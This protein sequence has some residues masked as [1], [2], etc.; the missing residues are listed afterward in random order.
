MEE[1]QGRESDEETQSCAARSHAAPSPPGP[2]APSEDQGLPECANSAHDLS[3]VIQGAKE[4]TAAKM[5]KRADRQM[6][7]SARKA[8]LQA[9]RNGK[10]YAPGIR[11]KLKVCEGLFVEGLRDRHP[12]TSF[13]DW[14]PKE[15][16]QCK[17]LLDKY[18]FEVVQAAL[19]YVVKH[20]DAIQSR[21]NVGPFPSL[22]WVVAMH[23]SLVPEAQRFAGIQQTLTE[24]SAWRKDHPHDFLPPELKARYNKIKPELEALGIDK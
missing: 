4:K 11:K 21:F 20:W 10:T 19:E 1:N 15:R 18:P 7:S 12:E 8:Q 22:G 14:G 24:I 17:Q 9:N 2:P 3:A 16:G 23:T 5:R 6:R 13:A